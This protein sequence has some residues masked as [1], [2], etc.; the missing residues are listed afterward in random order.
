M[1]KERRPLRL[2]EIKA[3]EWKGEIFGGSTVHLGHVI[4]D[5]PPK[6]SVE[7]SYITNP[8]GFAAV[9]SNFTWPGVLTI[10]APAHL[11]KKSSNAGQLYKV[12]KLP[13]LMLSLEVERD[14]FSDI[15]RALENKRLKNFYFSL[16]AELDD[17]WPVRAWGL[18]YEIG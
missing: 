10:V 17:A 18:T 4:Q 5:S 3:G 6:R 9:G 14:Q 13:S 8:T 15:L 16:E 1:K 12:K 7:F 11:M 2:P